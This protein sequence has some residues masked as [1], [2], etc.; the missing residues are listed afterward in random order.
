MSSFHS[1]K[2]ERKINKIPLVGRRDSPTANR[3]ERKTNRKVATYL[4]AAERIRNRAKRTM[5]K[6][7]GFV[8]LSLRILLNVIFPKNLPQLIK[9]TSTI[10]YVI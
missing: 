10:T 3:R 8:F 4:T 7:S 9:K 5:Y 6:I 1:K 2:A